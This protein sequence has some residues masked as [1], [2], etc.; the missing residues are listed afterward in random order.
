MG[1]E[2]GICV[3]HGRLGIGSG[4]EGDGRGSQHRVTRI[5]ALPGPCTSGFGRIDGRRV[6]G[7]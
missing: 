5:P 6:G 7:G 4:A 2:G 1:R 3:L